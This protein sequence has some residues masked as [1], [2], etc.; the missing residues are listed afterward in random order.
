MTCIC[1][2]NVNHAGLLPCALCRAEAPRVPW[3]IDVDNL[4]GVVVRGDAK[5]GALFSED[6]RHRYA[7]W[8]TW[9]TTN[10]RLRLL[11]VVGLNPS[12]ATHEVSD[13]T[14]TRVT[15][16]AGQLGFDGLVMLNLGSLRSTDPR[17]ILEDEGW[18]GGALHDWIL[19]DAAES[20]EMVLAAWGGPYQP[21][22]LGRLVEQRAR[23]VA[24]AL[25][26][27]RLHALGVTKDGHPR[28]PLY[29][30]YDVQPTSWSPS[31]LPERSSPF[32]YDCEDDEDED[33][34]RAERRRRA[35]EGRESVL[36]PCG[37]VVGE[38]HVPPVHEPEKPGT[39]KHTTIGGVGCVG[40]LRRA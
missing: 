29:Q 36:E 33:E 38:W 11:A 7:L 12:T 8:R 14:V 30:S 27:F 20:A 16:R 40:R 39:V 5:S 6:E 32:P 15:K 35:D 22:K 3:P 2:L 37:S 17:G 25:T 1:S 26:P 13:P 4:Y 23:D 19:V 31:F 28:H 34:E 24:W 9:G 18:H 10:G 21:R